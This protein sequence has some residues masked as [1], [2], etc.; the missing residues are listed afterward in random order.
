[1]IPF[2]PS[3]FWYVQIESYLA[4][5]RSVRDVFAL[6]FFVDQVKGITW[7]ASLK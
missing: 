4:I 7:K 2:G 3:G 1:M 5:L 6:N